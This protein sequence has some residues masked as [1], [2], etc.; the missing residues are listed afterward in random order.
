MLQIKNLVVTSDSHT[1]L[2]CI[3]LKVDAGSVTVLMGPNGSGK[4]TLAKVI[5]GHPAYQVESGS[6]K[7]NGIEITNLAVHERAHLGIFLA[8][9]APTEIPGVNFRNYLRLAYNSNKSKA[10]QLPVFKFRQLLIEQ[11]KNLE[12]EQTLL[13]RNLHEG[14]SGG[15]KKKM[16]ILQM[17]ILKPKLA[18]LDET[19]SGLDIDALKSVFTGIAKLKKANPAMTILLITHYHKIF[20]YIKPEIVHII[21]QGKI[22]KS[23]KAELLATIEKDG[24][25]KY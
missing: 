24:Y 4:S 5:L 12:I 16:E 1:I 9:Q 19:D 15:E 11:A 13:D 8:M 7:F 3:N 2:D 18:I 20:D 21:K 10:E 22:I 23:G 14:L 6:I 25:Q 17:A